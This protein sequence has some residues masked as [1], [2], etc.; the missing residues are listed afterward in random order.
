[1]NHQEEPLRRDAAENRARLLT[2]AEQV[3]AEH[4]TDASIEDIA[5]AAGVEEGDGRAVLLLHRHVPGRAVRGR[6]QVVGEGPAPAEGTIRGERLVRSVGVGDAF[7]VAAGE[8]QRRA[9]ARGG[10]VRNSCPK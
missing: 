4:G 1:M 9:A 6:R 7:G 10:Q 8:V 3:F 5:R 2:A